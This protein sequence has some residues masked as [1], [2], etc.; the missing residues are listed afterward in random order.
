MSIEILQ[1]DI[2][3]A[4]TTDTALLPL[5]RS[6]RV[7]GLLVD[8]T[9][10]GFTLTITD[11]NGYDVLQGLGTVGATGLQLNAGDIGGNPAKGQLTANVT[12]G[13]DTETAT[14]YLYVDTGPR[15]IRAS[16]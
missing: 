12:G 13:T 10:A 2:T 3:V 8:H 14:V 11:S 6:G 4:G 15:D 1:A 9:G 5:A 16:G 7:L